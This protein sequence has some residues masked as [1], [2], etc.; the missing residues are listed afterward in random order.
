[1]RY[2]LFAHRRTSFAYDYTQLHITTKIRGYHDDGSD[3]GHISLVEDFQKCYEG[4]RHQE[5]PQGIKH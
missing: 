1:M 3:V 2:M 4:V 5:G